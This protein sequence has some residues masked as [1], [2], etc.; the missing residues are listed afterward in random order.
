MVGAFNLFFLFYL[1]HIYPEVC[2]AGANARRLL[3]DT[4]NID[5]LQKG[6]LCVL[7]VNSFIQE[8]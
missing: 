8:K 1:P 7:T 3:L 4:Y 2:L 6:F 5:L